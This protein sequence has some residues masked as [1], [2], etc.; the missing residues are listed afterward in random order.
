MMFIRYRIEV[1]AAL[2]AVVLDRQP[3][4]QALSDVRVPTQ[5]TSAFAS[6]VRTCLSTLQLCNCARFQLSIADVRAWIE[7]GRPGDESPRPLEPPFGFSNWLDYAVSTFDSTAYTVERSLTADETEDVPTRW[8]V[9]YTLEEEL[10]ALRRMAKVAD[11][12]KPRYPRQEEGVRLTLRWKPDVGFDGDHPFK[13]PE[14]VARLVSVAAMA[15]YELPIHDAVLVW[16]S[17]SERVAASWLGMDERTDEELL[18]VI[19][20]HTSPLR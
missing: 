17:D 2:Q 8:H 12:L 5:D 18:A 19:L 20:E 1:R 11:T 9:Q 3:L 13:F 7:A 6:Y 10:R 14:D 16:R 15:G 4:E